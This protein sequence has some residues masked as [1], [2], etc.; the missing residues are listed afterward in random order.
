MK[1]MLITLIG[2]CS[3]LFALGMM[4]VSAETNGI[5]TYTVSNGKVTITDC[6]TSVSGN[7]VI[8]ETLGGYPVTS[9]GDEAFYDCISLTSITIP[10]SVTSIGDG[11]FLCCGSLTSVTIGNALLPHGWQ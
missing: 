10:N 6:S 9:I 2:V 8:P 5:Y 3:I 7:I 11:A 4:N 1:K